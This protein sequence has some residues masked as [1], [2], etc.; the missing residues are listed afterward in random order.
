ML[1]LFHRPRQQSELA[2][3]TEN[4]GVVY[5]STA[6]LPAL[7]EFVIGTFDNYIGPPFVPGIPN[8]VPIAPVTRIW[9]QGEQVL[10]RTQLPLSLARGSTIHEF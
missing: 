7:P 3:Q 6:G 5:F 2:V 4:I 9:N 10:S 1:C 8:S